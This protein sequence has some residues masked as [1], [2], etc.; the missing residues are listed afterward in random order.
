MEQ[1][2]NSVFEVDEI[3]RANLPER[4]AAAGLLC[5]VGGIIDERL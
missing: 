3:C 2:A 1:Q 4:L 5:K